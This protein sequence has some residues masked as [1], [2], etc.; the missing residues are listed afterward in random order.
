MKS[1]IIGYGTLNITKW[2]AYQWISLQEAMLKMDKY[3]CPW[4]R[5]RKRRGS[6]RWE[7]YRQ[8]RMHSCCGLRKTSM[9][10]EVNS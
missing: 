9:V 2:Y 6:K 5:R 4:E 8:R 3:N 10:N 1:R 7:M